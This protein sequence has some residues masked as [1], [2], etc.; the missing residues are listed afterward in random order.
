MEMGADVMTQDEA[1]N[2]ALAIANERCV[3]LS[4]MDG[5]SFC[6]MIYKS[7]TKNNQVRARCWLLSA[8]Y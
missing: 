8:D 1:G 4:F 3:S 7:Y 2:T 6:L 5:Q